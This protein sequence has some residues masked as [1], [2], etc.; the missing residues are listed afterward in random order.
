MKKFV[1]KLGL[2]VVL[3]MGIYLSGVAA[4]QLLPPQYTNSFNAS[5]LDKMERAE[6]IDQPKMMVIGGSNIV[7]GINSRL[8]EEE[9][10]MPVVNMG[11]NAG[12][13]SEFQLNVAEKYIREGDVIILGFEYGAY[14]SEQMNPTTAWYT[15]ENYRDLWRC[16]PNTEKPALLRFYPYYFGEKLI[17]YI[18]GGNQI[19]SQPEYVRTN[20]DEYG[21]F[22]FYRKE[23]VRK[24]IARNMV[25]QEAEIQ[26]NVIAGINE[27]CEKARKK[28]AAVYLTFPALDEKCVASTLEDIE[29]FEKKIRESVDCPV[30]S[31]C[32]TYLMDSRLFYD[33]NY[34]LNTEG[35]K[36][37]TRLLISDIRDKNI[38]IK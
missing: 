20:F 24:D 1:L 33:T 13:M 11:V 28:G 23:N 36:I 2:L 14:T 35:A 31:S 15:I 37:R 10:Q 26:D 3:V 4:G 34:H 27:F 5:L 16:V 30:I 21:D 29:E 38:L 18:K 7:F 19:P 6:A 8:L 9:F 32:Q 22:S 25:I 17:A 12:M